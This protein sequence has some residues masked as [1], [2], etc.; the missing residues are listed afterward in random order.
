MG[1]KYT[2][3]VCNTGWKKG[4]QGQRKQ[5]RRQ[6]T[7]GFLH[8]DHALTTNRTAADACT[9]PTKGLSKRTHAGPTSAE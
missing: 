7:S 8:R 3:P 2:Y 6:N 1:E 5:P 4:L 9:G